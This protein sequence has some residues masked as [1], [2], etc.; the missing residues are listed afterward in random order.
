MDRKLVRILSPLL[1]TVII[2]A[3]YY[4]FFIFGK[5]P[6]PGDLLVASYSPW[7]DFYKI[8]VQNPLISDVFSLLFIWKYLAVDQIKNLQW[9]L[10]NPYAFTGTPLLA[11]YQSAALYPLNLLLFLKY[12]GWGLF[13]F[14]QTLLAALGMYLFLGTWLDSKLARLTG[15]I[16]FALSGLMTTWVEFGTAVWGMAYLPIS[17]FL[18]E[19]YARM[20]KM[21]YPLILT[22]SLTLTIL[23]GNPQVT[24]YSFVIVFIFTVARLFTYDLLKSLARFL[25]IFLAMILSLAISAP[26]L[27]PTLEL[28]QKSIRATESYTEQVN[29]GLL[30]LTNFIRFFV[31]DFFG[32]PV[33][34]NYWGWLNYFESSNFVGSLTL[35][36]IIFAVLFLRRTR[37]TYFFFLLLI[38]SIILC[39]NNPLSYLIYSFK[40]PF[41]TQSFASRMLFVTTFAVSIL[42][43]FSLNQIISSKRDSFRKCLIWSWAI[44]T[45]MLLGTWLAYGMANYQSADALIAFRNCI[46]PFVE[47]SI[48][49]LIYV[50]IIK[51][52]FPTKYRLSII[53][54]ILF[55]ILAFDLSRYFLKFNPFVPEE[56]VFPQTPALQFLQKYTGQFRI[57]R[58]HAQVLPPNTWAAYKLQ[59]IEG[60]DVLHLLQFSKIM[61]HINN[62]NL[63]SSSTSRYEELTN[64]Q[65]A[66]IDAASVKYFIVIGKNEKGEIPGGL[67]DAGFKKTNYQKVF[68]D[69]SAMILEN[70]N[71]LPKAYFAKSFLIASPSQIEN[72]MA[73]PSFDPRTVA[74][75]SAN[76]NTKAVT[77]TGSAEVISFS[78]NQVKIKTKTDQEEILIL[79]DQYEDGW[80]AKIDGQDSKI[81]P[82]NLI[83]RAV[84]VPVGT[85]EIIFS[86][87]PQSFDMGL[88]IAV[89]ALLV[90]GFSTLVAFRITRL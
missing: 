45:G 33:T 68:Q 61:S 7:F 28:V 50:I 73:N 8:P 17:L 4:K 23:S 82:A 5:I 12:A 1:L 52:N 30:P 89:S 32:N 10:W 85:H 64:Y 58:E 48:I 37:I 66:F 6:F 59:S 44:F 67:I 60:Y 49:G 75:L 51:I 2:F 39:F 25:P 9:P 20:H 31:A 35:P 21:R 22:L 24:V 43:A 46:L 36:L 55:I 57:G 71:A 70:S 14:A 56:L 87:Y 34:N 3:I 90:L 74:V 47:V 79:A 81:S 38:F 15:S 80:R 63:L 65:S 18:I 86:Y 13:I 26:Q 42:A 54:S 62:G 76:L 88:K 53:C 19:R 78:P 84:K 40:M 27:L 29:F 72:I 69:G 11:N 77:G 16:I 83:F 41:L